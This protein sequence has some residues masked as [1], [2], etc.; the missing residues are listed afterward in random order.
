MRF[1][2]LPL[3]L[4]CSLARMGAAQVA[5]TTTDGTTA[6][7]PPPLGVVDDTP[8][9]KSIFAPSDK[10]SFIPVPIAFYQQET[11]FA[12]GV[13]ILPIWRF[14]TDTTVRKSNARLLAW[15][16]QEKQTT[17]QLTH[18]IFTPGEKFYF[19]G[20]LS[21]YDLVFNYYGIGN[22]TRKSD[23][24]QIQYPLFVFD[25]KALANVAPNLFVGLRYRLTNL[26]DVKLQD[27][28]DYSPI[29]PPVVYDQLGEA[30][31]VRG[32]GE[33]RNGIISSGVGPA[34]LYDGRD[35]VLATYRGNFVDAHM[36]F[37]GSALG[38][39]Y[40][41]TRYQVDAR[42]FNPLFGSN[43]TIFAAQFM[44]QYHSGDVPFR[45]LGG[46]GATLGGS[47]Y[48]N[49]YL[50][51]GIYENRFRDRQFTTVQAEIRQK[52]FWRFDVVGFLGAG[53]VGYKISDYTFDGTKLAGGLGARFRFNRRDRLN[54]RLDYGVGSGGNS[55]IIFAVGEA[56]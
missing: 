27:A 4:L 26:G 47:L 2:Y 18:T 41:F 46:M 22:N 11:G 33:Q 28:E 56:F 6:P 50:M 45:E 23:E 49:A 39:D 34:I 32:L 10:P 8:K 31:N 20:E 29:N 52:L 44:G 13:A 51:R 42:H 40:K 30:A 3:I 24:V 14:G 48:N 36:L 12:A 1:L 17:V 16:S 35:N 7:A 55:G 37:N 53:Q 54:I 19:S 43:N 38:S 25:E 15:Y 5:P 9:K 21:Y